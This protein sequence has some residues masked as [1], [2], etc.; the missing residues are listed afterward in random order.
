MN[1]FKIKQLDEFTIPDCKAY[2]D[3]YPYGE[4]YVEVAKRLKEIKSGK[5]KIDSQ[6]TN[7]TLTSDRKCNNVNLDSHIND[8][9]ETTDS[10]EFDD[11]SDGYD[12]ND[13]SSSSIDSNNENNSILD[14]VFSVIWLIIAGGIIILIVLAVVDAFMSE[15]LSNFLQKHK[16][17]IYAMLRSLLNVLKHIR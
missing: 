5:I 6:P 11:I 15:D 17:P 7:E 13:I 12:A 8:S 2:L 16:G 4:H 14:K 1:P 3:R 9:I 10:E